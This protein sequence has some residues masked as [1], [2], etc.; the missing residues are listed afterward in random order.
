M[1]GVFC[2]NDL[3]TPEKRAQVVATKL[4]REALIDRCASFSHDR[5]ES[6]LY[7][8]FAPYVSMF[9]FRSKRPI[10]DLNSREM[11]DGHD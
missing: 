3:I 8:A 5:I 4:N 10:D 2:P 6:G 1:P 11:H 9:G 7:N